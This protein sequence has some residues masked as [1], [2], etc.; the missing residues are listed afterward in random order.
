MCEVLISCYY[1]VISFKIFYG[2][3]NEYQSHNSHIFLFT[4]CDVNMMLVFLK[5]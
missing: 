2:V 4:R 1:S 3:L 5:E